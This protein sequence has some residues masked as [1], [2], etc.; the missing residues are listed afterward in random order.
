MDNAQ[1]LL[2]G[3]LEA[4]EKAL[5]SD[6]P[7]GDE[8]VELIEPLKL[9]SYVDMLAGNICTKNDGWWAC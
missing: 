6:M 3:V 5:Q 8:S 1:P 2:R 9:L 7:G 4:Y